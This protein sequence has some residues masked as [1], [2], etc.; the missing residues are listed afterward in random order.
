MSLLLAGW[1]FDNSSQPREP[2]T[3]AVGPMHSPHLFHS[4]DSTN[5]SNLPVPVELMTEAD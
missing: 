3:H 2:G 4:G 5:V 1:A